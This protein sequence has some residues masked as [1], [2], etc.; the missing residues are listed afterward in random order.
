MDYIIVEPGEDGDEKRAYKYPFY[1][2]EVFNCEIGEI[3]DLFFIRGEIQKEGGDKFSEE[4]TKSTLDEEKFS[5][6]KDFENNGITEK[7]EISVES[8]DNSS[9]GNEIEEN[10][11]TNNKELIE[12]LEHVCD[13]NYIKYDLLKKLFSFLNTDKELNYVLAGYFLKVM[14]IIIEKRKCDLLSYLF[15]CKEHIDN[16]IKHCYNKSISE[17]LYKL[18]SSEDKFTTGV[19]SESFAL[20]KQEILDKLIENIGV[21]NDEMVNNSSVVLSNL[22]NSRQ[23]LSYFLSSKVINKLFQIATDN[24]PITLRASLTIIN[25]LIKAKLNNNSPS[26]KPSVFRFMPFDHIFEGKIV[27]N[28]KESKTEEMD[29]TVL[30][31]ESAAHIPKLKEYLER[32][33]TVI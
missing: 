17:I 24:N 3:I 15:A 25:A 10:L 31:K 1:A 4:G 8:K 18:I 5:E 9:L 6:L 23:Y 16:F 22:I 7:I 28:N 30:T 11:E 20:E 26:L 12:E 14:L 29:I 33:M 21:K 19:S 13:K 27:N 32:G 2:S